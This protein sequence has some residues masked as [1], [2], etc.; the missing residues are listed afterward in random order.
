MLLYMNLLKKKK[1][2][3]LQ[4]PHKHTQ[5]NH[6]HTKHKILDRTLN[7]TVTLSPTT[8]HPPLETATTT[9]PDGIYAPTSRLTPKLMSSPME[10]PIPR[11]VN[12]MT[13]G[14]QGTTARRHLTLHR[15]WVRAPG[16]RSGRAQSRPSVSQC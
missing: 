13:A 9:H 7:T 12:E 14:P 1:K 6:T 10:E 11:P 16:D 4:N 2:K 8:P 15:P 3:P 5:K